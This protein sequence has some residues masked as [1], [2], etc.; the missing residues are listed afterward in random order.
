MRQ[1]FSSPRMENVERVAQLLRDAGIDARITHGRSYKGGLRGEFS[2]RDHTRVDPIP[3][4]WIVRS[5]DQPAAREILRDAGLLDSTRGETG[6]TLPMFRTETPQAIASPATKRAFRLKVGL[7][8]VITMI[9]ALA[10]VYVS[11]RK[12]AVVA[13]IGKAQV[14]A[15]L[16]AGDTRTPDTLAVAVLAGELPT[17]PGRHVCLSVDGN[18]PSPALLAVLP[19]APGAVVPASRCPADPQQ[20]ALAIGGYRTTNGSRG[21][22][23]LAR[24]RGPTLIASHRYDVRPDGTGWSVIQ[25]GLSAA[26]RAAPSTIRHVQRPALCCGHGQRSL[27]RS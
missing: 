4:V 14:L 9:I 5:E 17:L 26:R 1:V 18:D 6:Y 23:Q 20:L 16:P 25:P 13:T 8:L 3:A 21:S 24:H 22:I 11:M 7:L 12:P 27:Q 19:A 10:Y 2:Y 15:V